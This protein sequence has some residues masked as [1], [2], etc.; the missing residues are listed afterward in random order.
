MSIAVGNAGMQ[1]GFLEGRVPPKAK[2]RFEN[3]LR[4]L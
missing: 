1:D 4:N 2:A 3:Q